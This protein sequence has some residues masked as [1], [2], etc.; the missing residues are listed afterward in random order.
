MA[1]L[2]FSLY[3][4]LWIIQ[5]FLLAD[6][7]HRLAKKSGDE[8]KILEELLSLRNIVPAMVPGFGIY[9]WWIFKDDV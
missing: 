3:T 4:A 9:L 8:S 1:E 7:R 6:T 2:A 5:V